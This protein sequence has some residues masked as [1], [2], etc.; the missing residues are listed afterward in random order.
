MLSVPMDI[1][2]GGGG[3]KMGA[4]PLMAP[5]GNLIGGVWIDKAAKKRT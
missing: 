4:Y 1:A 2:G 3:L 5:F